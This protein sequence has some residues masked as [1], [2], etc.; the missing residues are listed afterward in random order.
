M[1]EIE[2]TSFEVSLQNLMIAIE[3]SEY[4]EAKHQIKELHPGEI[5]LLLEAIQPKDRS[6]LWPGIKISIQGEILKEVNEDVQSQ[7]ISEMSVVSL[8]KSSE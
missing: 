2:L 3:A 4:D 8:V 7:L 5:A 6:I 1:A